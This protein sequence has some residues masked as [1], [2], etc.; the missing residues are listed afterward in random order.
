MENALM[1]FGIA[2]NCCP[3]VFSISEYRKIVTVLGIPPIN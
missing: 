1:V 2:G 3:W